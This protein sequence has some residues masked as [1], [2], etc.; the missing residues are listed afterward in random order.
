MM[1]VVK[2]RGVW[3]EIADHLGH[4]SLLCVSLEIGTVEGQ[5]VYCSE[6]DDRLRGRQTYEQMRE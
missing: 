5:L 3:Y 6:R 2:A 1:V 4:I